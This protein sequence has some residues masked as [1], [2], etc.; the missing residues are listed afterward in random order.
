MITEILAIDQFAP[1]LEAIARAA[2]FIRSG[3]LVAFPT[4]TVYGLGGNALDRSAVAAIFAAK[5][6]PSTN[7]LIVH[8]GEA[9]EV[10]NVASKWPETA[11]RLAQRFWPGP[12]TLVLPKRQGV[13]DEVTAN[14]S[15][16]AVRCPHH[17]V[18]QALIRKSGVPIAAPSANRSMELSPTRGEHV[19][20]SLEGRI[21]LILDGGPCPG[22]IESTVV[23]VTSEVVRLLRH[24]LITVPMLESVVGKVEVGG[25]SE[26]V[27]RAPGQM[28][29]HYSPK[30]K[31][32]LIEKD[33]LETFFA[34]AQA[35]GLKV[36]TLHL[37][38]YPVAAAA[39]LYDQ[40]FELDR[41]GLDL[42]VVVQPPDTAE[43][44]AI[45]DRLSRASWQCVDS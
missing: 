27:A 7:P 14:G 45:R 16:V 43:W 2:D 22:G 12:L 8:V 28:A 34:A 17:A 36:K 30:T 31:L 40:L 1:D 41:A 38:P 35:R 4:E 19:R 39:E 24:G 26:G 42:I 3:R 11:E 29:R 6:R 18:A 25:K 20:I 5:G 15:T 37:P 9:A 32:Q 33:H 44:A 10:L 23:D 13:P 21:D